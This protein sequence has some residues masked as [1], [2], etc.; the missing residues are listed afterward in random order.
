MATRAELVSATRRRYA[1]ALRAQKKQIL[2]EF[3]AV[4]GLHRKHATRLL[5]AQGELKSSGQRPQR[6]V[7]N[8]AVRTA[9]IMVW[10]ASY[11]IYGK[12]L[13][14]LIRRM[15]E[16]M[17]RHGRLRLEAEARTQLLAMSA[18]TIDRALIEATAG[19]GQKR[20]RG[21]FNSVRRNIPVRTFSDW[22]DPSPGYSEADLVWHSGLT[23]KG[24]FIQTLVETDIAAGWTE[25]APLLVREQTQVL[26][27]LAEIR[28]LLPF[29]TA[30]LRHGWRQRLPERDGAGLVFW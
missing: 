29:Y 19:T 3:V 7:Y 30:W 10:E 22:G 24:S 28:K 14:P 8:E 15:V 25:C 5:R 16:A 6:R 21:S 17:E 23:G 18:A 9:L 1:V 27:V 13:K 26:L 20:R 11:R 4:T 2:D 12:R